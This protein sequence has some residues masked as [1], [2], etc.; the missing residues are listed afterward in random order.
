MKHLERLLTDMILEVIEA[1]IRLRNIFRDKPKPSLL[2]TNVLWCTNSQW[3]DRLVAYR[4]LELWT[5]R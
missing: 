2:V 1:Y 3:M 5:D 4:Q